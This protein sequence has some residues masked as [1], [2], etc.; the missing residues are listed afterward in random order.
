MDIAVVLS[1]GEVDAYINTGNPAPGQQ[2]F[3][4]VRNFWRLPVS[5]LGD[6]YTGLTAADLNHDGL[7]DLLLGATAPGGTSATVLVML[8]NADPTKRTV[9]SYDLP[10]IT[11]PG[12]TI[13][14][15]PIAVGDLNGDG[16]L[17]VIENG[18]TVDTSDLNVFN[19]ALGDGKGGLA[20][21]QSY[22]LNGSG[23][24]PTINGGP[25]A[26]G[27]IKGD[28]SLSAVILSPSTTSVD[29][30][31][32]RGNGVLD[33]V[34]LLDRTMDAFKL[35]P[36]GYRLKG[37][38]LKD[39]N[40]DLKPDLVF[41]LTPPD[42][43]NSGPSYVLVYVNTGTYPYFNVNDPLLFQVPSGTTPAIS[44]AITDAN[45]DGLE[46][47]L[48]GTGD[49]SGAGG[50]LLQ[51]TSPRKQ[52]GI[53]VFLQAGAI[54][55]GNNFLNVQTPAANAVYGQVFRDDD[56]DGLQGPNETGTAGTVVFVDLQHDGKYDPG[57][58]SAVT[59]AN[60]LFSIP[61][62][63]DGIYSVGVLPADGW[64]TTTPQ[65]MQV[66]VDGSTAAEVNFGIAPRLI[67]DVPSPLANVN[68]P[69][70][71]TVP[72]TANTAGH[73]LVFSLE[74]GAPDGASIDPKTGVFTWTPTIRDAGQNVA[75]TVRVRDVKDPTF[76]ETQSFTISVAGSAAEVSFVSAL[77]S[78]L[79]GRIADTAGL[80]YWIGLLDGG[81][82]RQQIAQG[83]WDSP[84]HLGLEVDQFYTTYLHRAAEAYGRGYW[85]NAFL[86]GASE[87]RVIEG[88]L[89]SAE[90]QQAHAGTTAYLFGLYADVLGRTPDPAGLD[91][92]QAAAQSGMSP[93]QIANGFLGSLEADEQRVGGYY[94]DYLGRDADA[95][96]AQVWLSLLQSGQMSP[97]QVAQAFLAS[98]EFFARAG[99]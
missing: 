84:E 77:Y 58:P 4:L 64:R 31:L 63:P 12:V 5:V 6:S 60:G 20:P 22:H 41:L 61:N 88:I 81:A 35:L 73:K 57:D 42:G 70:S 68:Q 34:H 52:P 27:D 78:T 85:T 18:G 2:R 45:N 76:T 39:V 9:T 3:V 24:T 11:G 16:N 46:D 87:E 26:I 17:D 66:R 59:Q 25:T 96:G 15:G 1:T 54:A 97:A 90:Y 89:T 28:G 10:G 47:I 55:G 67:G 21:W 93:A 91:Y 82:T 43:A 83:I 32:N 29:L 23:P 74:P 65:F 71:L 86:Y 19:V 7:D 36:A 94:R 79:L 98:D 40:G 38:Q 8:N 69:V 95:A 92:W 49:V 13:Q 14:A 80:E 75:V 51:N 53:P 99:G 48:V 62:L 30:A 50:Y 33:D 56:R 44:F 37:V 72:L